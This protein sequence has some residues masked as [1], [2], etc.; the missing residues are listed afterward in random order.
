[1]HFGVERAC[2]GGISK[3]REGLRVAPL[4]RE[5]DSQVERRIRIVWPAI[6]DDAKRALGPGE[7]LLLQRFP[8]VREAGV[9]GRH[10]HASIGVAI[11]ASIPRQD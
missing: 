9:D 8:S 5:G 4:P 2:R 3:G 6:E 7:L 1:M 11:D 10:T